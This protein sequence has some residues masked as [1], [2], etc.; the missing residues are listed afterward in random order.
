MN[1][2]VIMFRTAAA[3]SSGRPGRAMGWPLREGLERGGAR[4]FGQARPEF[5]LDDAWRD[6]V[7][8]HRRKF[9]SEGFAERLNRC[10]D[11]AATP[12][13]STTEPACAI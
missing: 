10:I 3:I 2:A 7:D 6:H 4:L 5:R 12:E 11:R 9:H 8:A 13:K 1:V